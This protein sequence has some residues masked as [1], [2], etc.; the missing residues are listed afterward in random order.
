MNASRWT[1]VPSVAIAI[2][3][4]AAL[5][6]CGG[7]NASQGPRTD[8]EAH[9]TLDVR[10]DE[11]AADIVPAEQEVAPVD[12]QT[13]TA[14][15]T[16][17]VCA[18]DTDCNQGERCN[19]TLV[20]P[21]CQTLYCAKKTEACDPSQGDALCM[22]GLVCTG[23]PSPACCAPDCAGK[24]CGSDGCGGSCGAC[25]NNKACTAGQ[26][27]C[28]GTTDTDCDNVDDD[29]DGSNDEHYV[30]V[31]SCFKPGACAAGN[32][33]SKCV[34]GVETACETGAAGTEV[35][36]G[37]DD[38]CN[39]TTDESWPT[40]GTVCT[41][42]TGT[43]QRTGTFTCNGSAPA[44]PVVCSA[45]AGTAGTE[46]CDGLDDDCDGSTDENWP[47]KGAVCTAGLGECLVSGTKICNAEAPGG[48]TVCSAVA[49]QAGTEVC[50]GLDDDCDGSND[51]NVCCTPN[52]CTNPP[53]TGC[54]ATFTRVLTYPAVGTCALVDLLA[55]C[56]YPQ[57]ETD[58]GASGLVC[59]SGACVTPAIKPTVAG[60]VIVTEFLARSQNSAADF[61]EWVELFNA[62][63]QT[64]DLGG[65]VLHDAGTAEFH[66][67]VGPLLV[68]AG[69]YLVLA[70]SADPVENHGVAPDYVYS[71]FTLQNFSDNIILTCFEVEIDSV[72]Y[73]S[74]RPQVVLGAAAQLSLAAY[75][76][77]SND[78][79]ANWCTAKS[80]YGSDGM[81]G[82]PGAAN[83]DCAP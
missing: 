55:S 13:P 62:T 14:C 43:C 63:G 9:D 6:G 41:V 50:N 16:R 30:P 83:F 53:K 77:V 45:T 1:S 17:Q 82:T 28:G 47:D 36:N 5:V 59:A 66:I 7:G 69:G 79:A 37:L 3:L 68:A 51:E 40:K 56:T 25:T 58:C 76:S 26:C 65:C 10:T 12:V 46:V 11:Q 23:L 48:P 24:V 70:N 60:Q 21:G 80:T 75:D 27:V 44:G 61:G 57:T 22:P 20:P 42:G 31:T 18:A 33:A 81:L 78:T 39:G 32:Q 38:N 4:T 8:V 29:C 71:N 72:T 15:I 54:D 74:G 73:E 35:C 64:L 52:P 49:D 67:I 19:L 2:F 34:G